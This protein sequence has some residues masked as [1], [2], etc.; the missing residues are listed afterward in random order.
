[1][2]VEAIKHTDVRGK[3][4]HYIKL[5]NYT[6][7]ELVINVGEKTYSSVNELNAGEETPNNDEKPA[8]AK[9]LKNKK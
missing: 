4:L 7:K 9:P 6:G 8:V 5:T 2:K 3:I 1:M